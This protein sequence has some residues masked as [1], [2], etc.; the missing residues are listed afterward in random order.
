M[1]SIPLVLKAAPCNI[2]NTSLGIREGLPEKHLFPLILPQLFWIFF[3]GMNLNIVLC[4][5]G[6]GGGGGGGAKNIKN[7]PLLVTPGEWRFLQSES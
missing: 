2:N 7:H 5:C 6:G 3:T 1:N 4:V